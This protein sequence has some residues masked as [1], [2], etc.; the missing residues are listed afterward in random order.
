MLKLIVVGIAVAIAGILLYAATRPD[1]FR[2][3]RTAS[4]K[5]PPEKIFPLIDDL[6]SGERWS[7]YYRKDPAMQGTYS[8]PPNG[9]GATFNFAGN[10]DVGAGRVSIT[11][12]RPPNHVSMR[13]Q[14]FKPFAADN[15][16]EFTLVPRGETT[17]VTWTMVGRQPYLAKVMCL[18][19]DMDGMI[20]TDF[21]TGLANLKTVAEAPIAIAQ[22]ETG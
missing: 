16:V 12:T 4:I 11:G 2:V 20:G 1:T 22:G 10:K 17:D 19:F 13:L 7:P 9:V 21:A 5:A 8:G 3:Q 14:M 6:R 18:F 15:T